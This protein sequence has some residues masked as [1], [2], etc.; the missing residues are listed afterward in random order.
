MNDYDGY[1]GD[2]IN[3]N[4]WS[5]DNTENNVILNEIKN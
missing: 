2:D 5:N 4:E 1:G 3:T